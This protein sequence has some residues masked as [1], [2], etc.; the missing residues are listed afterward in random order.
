M[1][2]RQKEK[3]DLWLYEEYRRLWN[4]MGHEPHPRHNDEIIHTVMEQINKA[5]IWIPEQEIRP[6]FSRRKNHY[7]N[8]IRKEMQKS[9]NEKD[10][11][12]GGTPIER[13]N[14]THANL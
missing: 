3:I 1:K 14:E 8:R 2:Q 10:E 6:H 4:Q 13:F 12:A 9:I 7:R 11:K 5:N